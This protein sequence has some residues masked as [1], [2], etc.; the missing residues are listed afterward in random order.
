MASGI[1]V[2][3]KCEDAFTALDKREYSR[4]VLKINKDMTMV[5]LDK[6]YPPVNG[7]PEAEWKTFIKSLP[8]NEARYII[9][10]FSWKET[11]TVVKSKIVMILWSP[12]YAPIRSKM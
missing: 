9:S 5:D 11:P 4:I 1:A 12:D 3:T 10:D 6:T 8:E 2:S 7:D